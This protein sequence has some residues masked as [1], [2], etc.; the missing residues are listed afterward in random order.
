[1]LTE[2]LLLELDDLR[3]FLRDALLQVLD[4]GCQIDLLVDDCK[5]AF[6]LECRAYQR[7]KEDF[8][9]ALIKKVGEREVAEFLDNA[10]LPALQKV[11]VLG[12]HQ[13]EVADEE[14]G[15]VQQFF[16]VVV[17]VDVCLRIRE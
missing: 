8:F 9:E 13:A 17:L 4:Q 7:W 6:I 3:K 15:L 14:Q 12:V 1:M 16:D 5:V 2:L 10:V 11:L